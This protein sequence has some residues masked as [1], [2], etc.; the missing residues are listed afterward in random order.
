LVTLT[1]LKPPE[2]P[3]VS[4][5]DLRVQLISSTE[6]ADT[7]RALREL[8]L[9]I[10]GA[11]VPSAIDALCVEAVSRRDGVAIVVAVND[12]G[13]VGAVVCIAD[14]QRFWRY[15]LIRHPAIAVRL[16]LAR[17]RHPR[18]SSVRGDGQREPQPP[19]ESIIEGDHDAPSWNTRGVPHILLI[20]VVDA[21]RRLGV[22]RALYAALF[23][24][25]R[26][27]WRANEILARIDASN[28]AS[29]RLHQS[30]GWCFHRD[31]SGWLCHV[32]LRP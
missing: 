32:A 5:P 19:P 14:P 6:V 7:A 2:V 15:F 11:V 27:R 8:G 28:T 10:G 9:S 26:D 20:G 3:S 12:Q 4:E 1:S 18:P 25:V 23:A 30:T 17:S 13:V 16:L 21:A 22:G 24:H 31:G 29:I